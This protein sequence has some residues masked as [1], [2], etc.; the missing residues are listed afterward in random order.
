MRFFV[1][2]LIKI[3]TLFFLLYYPKNKSENVI[4][5]LRNHWIIKIRKRQSDII[6]YNFYIFS[7]R[8]ILD[9]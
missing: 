7:S 4:L 6:T 9:I 5:H 8:L 2:M 3:S 1:S